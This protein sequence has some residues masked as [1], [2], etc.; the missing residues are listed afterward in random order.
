MVCPYIHTL[1][2]LVAS[3]AEKEKFIMALLSFY[4]ALGNKGGV[5][6]EKANHNTYTEFIFGSNLFLAN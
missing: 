3:E 6:L 1:Y 4:Y 5:Q 2:I